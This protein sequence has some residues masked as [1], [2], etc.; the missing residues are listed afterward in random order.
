[1]LEYDGTWAEAV[2]TDTQRIARGLRQRDIAL[3]HDLVEYQF[4]LVRYLIYLRRENLKLGGLMTWSELGLMIFLRAINSPQS[5]YLVAL[6]PFVVGFAL[7]AYSYLCS[8]EEQIRRHCLGQVLRPS[9][10]KRR[11]VGG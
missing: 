5:V 1:M 11:L 6:I 2:T 7:L 8:Q 10:S 9:R 4:R 3:L